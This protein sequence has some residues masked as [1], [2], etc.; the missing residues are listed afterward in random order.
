MKT[1]VTT[2]EHDV[3]ERVVWLGDTASDGTRSYV[4]PGY[5]GVHRVGRV[6]LECG[7]CSVDGG[8]APT[9]RLAA[10]HG[11]PG[12]GNSLAVGVAN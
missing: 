5:R 9:L 4:S 12:R 7:Q 8:H 2:R 6:R 1:G 3:R 11:G 10:G